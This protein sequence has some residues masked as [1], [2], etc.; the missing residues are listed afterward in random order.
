GDADRW[1]VGDRDFGSIG[2]NVIG[3]DHNKL[4]GRLAFR[5][6][7]QITPGSYDVKARL[8]DMDAMGVWAQICFQNGGVTQAGSLVALGDEQLAIAI[9]KVFNDACADRLK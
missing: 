8:Y 9:V 3:K 7:D 1:F 4:L 6:Y 2:G 5:N